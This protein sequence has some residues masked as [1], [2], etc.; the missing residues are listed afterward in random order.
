LESFQENPYLSRATQAHDFSQDN[1]SNIL[2][3]QKYYLYKIIVAKG[4]VR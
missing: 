1:V 4:F 2:K 3:R